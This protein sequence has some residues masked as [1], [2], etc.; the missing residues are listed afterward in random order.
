M[1]IIHVDQRNKAGNRDGTSWDDAYISI[2]TA[3]ANA[4]ASD[5]IVIACGRYNISTTLTLDTC[6]SLLGGFYGSEDGIDPISTTSYPTILDFSSNENEPAITLK[7]TSSIHIIR[8]MIIANSICDSSTH[9][10]VIT[11]SYN[12]VR[13]YG[14]QLTIT[15]CCVADASGSLFRRREGVTVTAG[16]GLYGCN[17]TN[18]ICSA[19]PLI[20]NISMFYIYDNLFASNV[21]EASSSLFSFNQ[22]ND[23]IWLLSN[24][25]IINNIAAHHILDCT[26]IV[27]VLNNNIIAYNGRRTSSIQLATNTEVAQIYLVSGSSYLGIPQNNNI[28]AGPYLNFINA[29]NIVGS[30]GNMSVNPRFVDIQNGDYSLFDNSPCIL[31]DGTYIGIDVG[32][33]ST[34]TRNASYIYSFPVIEGISPNHRNP[35]FGHN[36]SSN[37]VDESSFKVKPALVTKYDRKSQ[38]VHNPN[39]DLLQEVDI[40]DRA[41]IM[42]TWAAI[43]TFATKNDEITQDASRLYRIFAETKYNLEHPSLIIDPYMVLSPWQYGDNGSVNR[44]QGAYCEDATYCY[45]PTDSRL[46]TYDNNMLGGLTK[47]ESVW[48]TLSDIGKY[49]IQIFR[50]DI[51]NTYGGI[52]FTTIGQEIYRIQADWVGVA[53]NRDYTNKR[54]M[55]LRIWDHPGSTWTTLDSITYNEEYDRDNYKLLSGVVTDTNDLF[56]HYANNNYIYIAAYNPTLGSVIYTNHIRVILNGMRVR[57]LDGYRLRDYKG[58]YGRRYNLGKEGTILLEE[59]L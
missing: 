44:I 52:D 53:S 2:P 58:L 20:Q 33:T 36:S 55:E 22:T 41:E 51:T 49:P 59:I 37:P 57:W 7:N 31:P 10:T 8:N 32:K 25:T 6:V 12:N 3:V 35:Q 46:S 19:G 56:T 28:Y 21:V 13:F 27:P 24:N 9:G 45:E 11:L 17:I 1:A 42:L 26:G 16:S 39:K 34:Y 38:A 48:V 4:T 15:G 18:N 5:N 54:T 50:I 29:T 40:Q 30:N 47:L 43:D 23:T 14:Y